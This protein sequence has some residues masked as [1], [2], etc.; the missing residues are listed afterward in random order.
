MRGALRRALLGVGVASAAAAYP[1]GTPDYQTDA[2]PYCAS[3]HSSTNLQ[4]M[5]GLEP[6][7]AERELAANKHLPA[8]DAGKGD[9]QALT[10][11]E[12]AL[13]AE[14]VRAVDAHTSVKINA[15]PK[16]AMNQELRVVV[17][18]AG[19]AGPVVGVALVDVPHRYLA[20]PAPAVGWV[21]SREPTIL[22]QDFQEQTEWL[23]RRPLSMGRN[24]AY[25]NVVGL[26]SDA[27]LGEWA[28]AQ[29]IWTLR[30]PNRPGKLPLTAALW[31]GTEKASPLGV[32]ADPL[33]GRILR[34]GATGASGRIL[35]SAPLT[36]D[37]T[38]E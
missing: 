23:S 18:I 11:E 3:C 29:V 36:I 8:I 17:D 14:H 38:V 7:R 27:V 32:L 34:G 24:L 25:V 19:G 5:S 28:R 26:H 35:F 10:P 12:R 13:L 1:G 6:E 16:V 15:L 22:G 21:V 2:A 30:A 33:R 20:R 37:V 31:Y 9:Y 4:M